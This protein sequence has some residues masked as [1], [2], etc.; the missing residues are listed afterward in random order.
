MSKSSKVMIGTCVALLASAAS[1]QAG[2]GA[3][4]YADMAALDEYLMPRE[5]EIAMARSAAPASISTAAEIW[6]LTPNGYESVAGGTDGFTCLVERSWSASLDDPEF[7]NPRIRAPIC[8]NAAAARYLVP[9]LHLK[10]KAVI[11]TRSK[12]KMAEQV[13]RALARDELPALP[14][15]AMCFMMSSSGFL[16]DQNGHWHPH[17]MF[18][19]RHTPAAAWGANA[20]GS[21]VMA[22]TDPL[23][24]VTTFLVPVPNWSDGTAGPAH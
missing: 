11:G 18:F 10:S 1:I 24:D 6:V 23:D 21:A 20:A 22:F 8:F 16:G 14:A 2:N 15:G 3:T 7:W 19:E 9:L 4:R 12:D 17:L 5:Q 13:R